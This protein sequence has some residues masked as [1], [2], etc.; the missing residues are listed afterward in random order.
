MHAQRMDAQNE[1]RYSTPETRQWLLELDDVEK[2]IDTL[3]H[4]TLY[5]CM[6]QFG[7]FHEVV[8]RA[9]AC[10][11]EL[12]VL[13]CF[14]SF[15]AQASSERAMC[16]P[17]LIR[18][19]QGSQ[20]VFDVK[21]MRHPFVRP[22]GETF[23]PNDL[24]LGLSNPTIMLI[25]GPNMG[26]KSTIL[27]QVCVTAIMAQLGCYVAAESCTLTPVDRIF[28]RLGARDFIMAGKSTFFVE[29]E[30]TSKMLREATPNSLIIIDELGRGTSTFDGYAIAY[31]VLK[32][33]QNMQSRVMF[34]THYH[35][36]CDEFNQS[37]SVQSIQQAYMDCRAQQ[38]VIIA[39]VL[40]RLF[41]FALLSVFFFSR[42][43]VGSINVTHR[44]T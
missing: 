40:Q 4:Q 39:F 25:T 33:L 41:C 42:S 20:P 22:S 10:A 23:I 1:E 35:E 29:L 15:S 32:H 28:T 3:S 44:G 36:L 16:R 12:D 6:E 2:Q 24:T 7:E 21:G 43:L 8:S 38:C 11:A 5:A 27:R 17:T 30:E 26:G 18:R 31:S 19:V 14:A 37:D 9:V 13:A 34:S